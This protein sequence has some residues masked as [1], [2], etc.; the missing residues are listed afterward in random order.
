MHVYAKKSRRDQ[1][2]CPTNS[3]IL[4][5]PMINGNLTVSNNRGVNGGGMSLYGNSQ[6]EICPNSNLTFIG[7]HATNKGGGIYRESRAFETVCDII[8]IPNTTNV[9]F[10]F[11]NNT[12][13][14]GEDTYGIEFT[15]VYC[16]I[17][18]SIFKT[19]IEYLT[20]PAY[21]CFC[22]NNPIDSCS[23][24]MPIRLHKFPGQKIS[25]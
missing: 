11:I 9:S 2:F 14:I 10:Y 3:Q 6:L 12:A 1:N 13:A 17:N 5:P 21:V 8:S 19:N 20:P 16:S 22:T 7:N 4:Q 23:E 25:F 15:N 18:G 24:T